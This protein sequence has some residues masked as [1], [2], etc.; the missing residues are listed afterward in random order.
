MQ[1]VC[2]VC[3]D[4]FIADQRVGDRQR[5]C[6][7][8]ACKKERKRRAQRRWVEQNPGYFRGRYPN[9]KDWLAAHPGYLRQYRAE[10]KQLDLLKSSPDIQDKLTDRNNNTLTALKEVY[11]IQDELSSRIT[12]SKRCLN[13]LA[14]LIY[15]TSEG[16]VNTAVNYS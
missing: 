5:V 1:K 10:R 16:L 2:E 7:K 11:D 15:K 12:M 6:G 3:Q 13:R 8:P 9:T 4:Y 14:L